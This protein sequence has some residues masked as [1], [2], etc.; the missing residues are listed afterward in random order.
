MSQLRQI[1][2]GWVARRIRPYVIAEVGVNHNGRLQTALELADA[3]VDAGADCVKF[4]AFNADE[5]C[6]KAAPKA[7]YQQQ[8]GRPAESQYDML[9]RLE[10]TEKEFES[11]AE[12]C[13]KLGIDFLATPFSARWVDALVGVGATAIKIGSGNLGDTGLL[14]AVG[15]TTL[16]VILSTGMA[17]MANIEKAIAALRQA[18]AGTL[19]VLHCVSL[20]PTRLEQANL[21]AIR[22]LQERTGLVVGFSDHTEQTFTGAWAVAA[23][24]V[25]V[26]KHLTLDKK[27]EGPDHKMSLTPVEL[28]DYVRQ[29]RQAATA[30]GSG[31]KTPL[32]QE[33]KVKQVVTLSAVPT[34]FLRAGTRITEQMIAEGA[35]TAKRPGTGVPADQIECLSGAILSRD[36]AADEPIRWEDIESGSGR[37]MESRG[38]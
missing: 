12:H 10:L 33:N 4:Q 8:C 30:C 16:P 19:A 9:R 11:I 20:Y 26:E 15:Q 6:S 25:I 37:F 23:G 28:A 22:A 18:G 5:L 32:P 14:K 34:R 38:Q 1:E 2:P 35:F 21:Y 31:Q 24:A 27:A 29:A 17:D 7:D 3:A 13:R 36:V